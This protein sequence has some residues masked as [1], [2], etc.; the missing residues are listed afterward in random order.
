[1]PLDYWDVNSIL[2]GEES[3][4]SRFLV[5]APG[6]GHLDS[7]RTGNDRSKL[8]A[9]TILSL[10]VWL[11]FPLA[12]LDFIQPLLP[13]RYTQ[14]MQ[15]VLRKGAEGAR[16]GDKSQHYY[17]VGLGLSWL[18]PNNQDLAASIFLGV[19]QRVRFIIDHSTYTGRCENKES[20]FIHLFTENEPWI[21]LAGVMA[22][23][24]YDQWRDGSLTQ[25]RVRPEL[26]SLLSV[27]ASLN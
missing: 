8:E 6:L 15:N 7:L 13:E 3:L 22:N 1:M 25:I 4:E 27:N 5:N 11:V 23:E 21:Y 12:R 9:G 26:A 16:L 19:M 17:R 2:S 10:P 14:G 20:R 24:Q 18:I